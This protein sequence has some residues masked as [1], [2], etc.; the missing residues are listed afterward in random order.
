M[1]TVEDLIFAKD[2]E[3]L[4][5]NGRC[6]WEATSKSIQQQWFIPKSVFWRIVKK[7]IDDYGMEYI[8]EEIK[9]FYP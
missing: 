9:R 2:W 7:L 3:I 6:G 8:L 5:D 4:Y 1:G